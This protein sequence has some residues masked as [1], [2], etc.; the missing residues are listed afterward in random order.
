MM[1]QMDDAQLAE[2]S[3]QAYVLE[4]GDRQFEFKGF[5]ERDFNGRIDGFFERNHKAIG[6]ILDGASFVVPRVLGRIAD[7][8]GVDLGEIKFGFVPVVVAS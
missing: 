1:I 4:I 6:R 7:R 2:V 3:G 5:E 8:A